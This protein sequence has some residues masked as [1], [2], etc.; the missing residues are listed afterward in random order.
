[1]SRRTS[2]APALEEEAPL[3]NK[4]KLEQEKSR[5]Q[6]RVQEIWAR[7]FLPILTPQEKR[8]LAVVQLQFPLV[9]SENP[10]I[11]FHANAEK[12]TITIPIASLL[13]FEDL[14]TAYA[15]L[16]AKQYSHSTID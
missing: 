8:R 6:M 12:K 3:Y 7:A 5:L 14:S 9:G 1:M 10:L 2:L 15:W 11:D 16:W 4:E 13:F